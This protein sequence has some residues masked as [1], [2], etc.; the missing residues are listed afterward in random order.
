MYKINAVVA[1]AAFSLMVLDSGLALAAPE[2]QHWTTE[3]GARVYFISARELP[4]VDVQ[5]VFDAGSARDGSVSGLALLTNALLQSGTEGM[6]ANAVADKL[7]GVGA[8][9]EAGAERDMAWLS[10]RTLSDPQYRGSSIE[11]VSQ[12]L[13]SPAFSAESFARER[14]RLIAAIQES[15]QSPKDVAER[16]FYEALYG[17]HPYASPPEGTEAGLENV[18]RGDVEAFYRRY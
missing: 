15:A 6:N 18:T 12:I 9:L 17:D 2:I 14:G 16:A 5:I 3:N 13:S 11:I 1:W 7:D 10:L 8:Q 4:I